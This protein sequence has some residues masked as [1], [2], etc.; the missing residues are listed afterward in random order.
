[1]AEKNIKNT[2][3]NSICIP[4]FCIS[5]HPAPPWFHLLAPPFL[6]NPPSVF[7]LLYSVFCLLYSV[8]CL[9]YSVFCFLSSVFCFLSSAFYPSH[10]SCRNLFSL[11]SRRSLW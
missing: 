11:R 9:L 2:H 5:L 7:C 4:Q 1:M 10:P 8:F 3:P 6:R